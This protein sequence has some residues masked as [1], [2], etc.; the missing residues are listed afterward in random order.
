[1][2]KS[3]LERKKS[4]PRFRGNYLLTRSQKFI[5]QLL[6]FARMSNRS[7]SKLE[8]RKNK[9]AAEEAHQKELKRRAAQRARIK[10]NRNVK[11]VPIETPVY[12]A[13]RNALLRQNRTKF[14]SLL[15]ENRASRRRNIRA[16]GNK[17]FYR[18]QIVRLEQ[19]KQARERKQQLA[20][21]SL[22]ETKKA[23]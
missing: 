1:M 22:D 2:R 18:K 19:Q 3:R 13:E 10:A 9:L 21:A 16:G 6:L 23:A 5:D 15:D 14:V 12:D 17:P 20:E 4:G 11:I 7:K 8:N